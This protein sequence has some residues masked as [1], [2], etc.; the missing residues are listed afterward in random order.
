VW[1]ILPAF[2]ARHL[3]RSWKTVQSALVKAG[4]LKVTGNENR[5]NIPSSTVRRWKARLFSGADGLIQVLVSSGI[6]I[7]TVLR[8]LSESC[9][10]IEL[11]EELVRQGFLTETHNL[12]EFAGFI[13]RLVPG[14]RLM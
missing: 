14:I 5:V 8:N 11:V 6:R 3:H 10:R 2:L 1:T 12:S 4:V 9:S 7:S 13:H